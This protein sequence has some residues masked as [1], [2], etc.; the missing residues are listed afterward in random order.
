MD[1][2]SDFLNKLKMASRARKDSFAFPASGIILAIAA[3]LEKRG[4]IASFKKTRKGHQVEIKL[5]LREKAARASI[6]AKRVSRLSKRIYMRARDIRPVRNGFGAAI[7]S[8]PK[9]V[10]SDA[11]ARTAKVGGE[12]LFE[13]W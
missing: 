7:L 12:V 9:G 5:P 4:Y 10:L 8:T 11:E 3:A 6:S 2:I 13:I 1:P